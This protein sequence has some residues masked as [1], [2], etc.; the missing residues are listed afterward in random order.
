MGR[1]VT[2]STVPYDEKALMR[3]LSGSDR[4][5]DPWLTKTSNRTVSLCKISQM[6]CS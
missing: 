5:S 4:R 6:S 2:G 3:V 1:N